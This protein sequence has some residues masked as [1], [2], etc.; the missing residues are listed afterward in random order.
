MSERGLGAYYFGLA[1]A[2]NEVADNPERFLATYLDKWSLLTAVEEHKRFLV[3]GPKGTGKSAAAHYVRLAW[4]RK[5]GEHAVFDTFV[6]FDELNRTQSPLAALDKRLVGDVPALTDAA[7]RL[8]IGVRLLDSLLRDPA[9]SLTND[10]KVLQ[11]VERLRQSGLASEDFPQVLRK[12]RERKGNVT[13]PK[14]AG[15]EYSS[16]ESSDVPVSQVGDAILS[17]ITRCQS[18]NRHI[19][20]IDGLD[21]AI[22]D[23]PAYWQ[24]LAAL[25]RVADSL[26]RALRGS[27]ADHVYILIMCRSDVFRRV[28]FADAA[29]IAA[30]G[31]VQMD[32]GA[33]AEN[34]RDVQLWEYIADKAEAPVEALFALLP[35]TVHV[36]TSQR[37]STDRYL[38]QFTRYTPRDMTLLFTSLQQV[39]G[40][41]AL[42]NAQVR[43]GADHFSSRHLLTEIM[44]EAAGLLPEQMIDRFESILGSMPERVFERSDMA[45]ALRAAGFMSEDDVDRF[46]EYLFLQGAIGNF[47][48]GAG[49]VQFYHRR[50]AYKWQKS[51]PWVMHTGLVYAF[52][53]PWTNRPTRGASEGSAPIAESRPEQPGPA[54]RSTRP[55]RQEQAT[56]T[57]ATDATT[58][59]PIAKRVS[60]ADGAA[61]AEPRRRSRNRRYRGAGGP[62]MKGVGSTEEPR[63]PS[64][65]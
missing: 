46:G 10:P 50:D 43:R 31:A 49:Y 14:I 30:D 33:E 40:A 62:S 63:S 5:Y 35:P 20:A 6:D 8:F 65:G 2:E 41:S 51:G 7:W 27:S 42:S 21:K 28:R 64:Q 48:R 54:R 12:V 56:P 25:V 4:K 45:A 24:T 13:I 18:P 9:C 19:L 57:T 52:N 36:G 16:S 34:P 23:N 38:L 59:T 17:M 55:R 29:K 44:S 58:Q 53:V 26:T 11:F 61:Q 15:F 32:W 22:G 37:I 1:A 47:R 60:S 3:L 39:N